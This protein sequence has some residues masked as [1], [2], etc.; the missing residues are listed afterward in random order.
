[1]KPKF[2]YKF[3]IT[4]FICF[5]F[6]LSFVFAQSEPAYFV[7]FSAD[8]PVRAGFEF[9]VSILTSQNKAINAFDFEISYPKDKVRFLGFNK[10]N[11]MVDVW[12]NL[13]S[14]S[15]GK[16]FL[17]GGFLK[18]IAG[19]GKLI[20]RLRFKALD[21]GDI[22]IFF[23]KSELYK[24]DGTG[25]L[26]RADSLPLSLL[27]TEGGTV[28]AI[29]NVQ[30]GS[31]LFPYIL[32]LE[33]IR[34]LADGSSLASFLIQGQ[35]SSEPEMRVKI[36]LFWGDWHI[37]KNPV[38]VPSDAWAVQLR[39]TEGDWRSDKVVYDYRVLARK[40]SLF[41]SAIISVVILFVAVFK[42]YIYNKRR[43]VVL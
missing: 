43:K 17:S 14:N 33:I 16:I 26:I 28:A 41:F 24:A 11:S 10:A 3:G 38:S 12:Q 1:M 9:E 20:A 32:E 19:E 34:D 23:E 6:P 42:I 22:N 31:S 15:S 37:V 2:L 5:L 39:I 13:Y 25:T 7:S 29:E 40:L 36:W 27:A 4:A 35:A 30:A 18:P 8:N 21:F